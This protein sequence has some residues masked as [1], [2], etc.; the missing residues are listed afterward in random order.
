MNRKNAIVLAAATAGIGL[1]LRERFARSRESQLKGQVV[2]ITG[3]SKGLGIALARRFAMEGCRLA[4]CA[5]NAEELRRAK[6]DL[7][8][9]GADVLTL[10]CDVTDE[11]SVRRMIAAVERH[12]GSID[13][14]VNNAGQ[15]AVGPIASM[16]VEDFESAMKVMFW[17]VVYPT[18]AMLPSFLE[19]KKG[20]IVNITS[21]GGKVSVPHLV[22]YTCAKFAATGFSEGIRAEL[23]GKGIKVTTIAPGLM[24]TGS[25][26]NA[27]FKG[28]REAEGR[29]FSLAA[30][31]PILT[32]DADK[33]AEE[34]LM[35]T[36]LGEAER[37]LTSPAKLMS[38][39]HG[40]APGV[41]ADLLGIVAG[42]LLPG[43]G[44]RNKAK[45]GSRLAFIKSPVMRALLR[46]GLLARE[47][48]LQRSPRLAS[49]RN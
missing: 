44:P 28:D 14:L 48:Y 19:R 3:G 15:I 27:L 33:A 20:R 2:L 36:K 29:W 49:V 10:V 22:P 5:R 37:I 4:L 23:L 41:T 7:D 32:I 46:L 6:L 8:R 34:I 26:V 13:I 21:F 39:L 30:S 17:G 45:S 25:F 12:F 9:N 42:L 43:M 24:R 38:R 40:I 1:T 16:T 47:R 31:M 11:N 35:A 18:L